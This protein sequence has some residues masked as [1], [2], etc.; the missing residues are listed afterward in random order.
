VYDRRRKNYQESGW[1]LFLLLLKY[2][3][4]RTVFPL[5]AHLFMCLS[6]SCGDPRR[7]PDPSTKLPSTSR[8]HPAPNPKRPESCPIKAPYRQFLTLLVGGCLNPPPCRRRCIAPERRIAITE[9]N[10]NSIKPHTLRG[11]SSIIDTVDSPL[12]DSDRMDKLT[13]DLVRNMRIFD[14][15]LS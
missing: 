1:V 6:S 2:P 8:A 3:F 9:L 13:Y 4:A 7:L 12:V 11:R 10:L 14:D 5:M 15:W